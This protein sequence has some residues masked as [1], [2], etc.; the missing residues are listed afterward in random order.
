MRARTGAAAVALM[1]ASGGATAAAAVPHWM[2]VS[3][4]DESTTAD[5]YLT[6]VSCAGARFCMAAGIYFSAAF[7]WQTLT[8]QW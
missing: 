8:E 4:P 3:S 2:L 1:L 5:N 7:S 6:A